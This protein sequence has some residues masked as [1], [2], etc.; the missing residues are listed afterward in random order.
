LLVAAPGVVGG[1]RSSPIRTVD[2]SAS[3]AGALGVELPDVDGRAV[4]DLLPRPVGDQ[5]RRAHYVAA[6]HEVHE[7]DRRARTLERLAAEHHITRRAVER[8]DPVVR[9]LADRAPEVDRDLTDHERRIIYLER[10][11]SVRSTMAWVEQSEV[12][13]SLLVSVITPT[14]NRSSLLPR[15]IAS[16]LAQSYARWEHVVIDDGSTDP[17]P[18]VLSKYDDDRVKVRRTTGVGECAARNRGLDAATGDVIVYLD[19]DNVLHPDWCKA[20]VWAFSQR[21]AVEVLYGARIIDDVQRATGREPGALPSVQF[22][23]FDHEGLTR[24]N[25][26]D[27]GVMAHRS[28]LAEARFDESLRRYGDWDLF[29]RLTRHRPP[30]ELPVLAC[31]YSTEA[32]NR[33]TRAGDTPEDVEQLRAKFARLLES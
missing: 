27:M 28:G 6:P 15:A 13:E 1:R 19:D 4:P 24:H 32:D 18:E 14:R 29:W 7:S 26:A 3:L 10:L 21:P 23:P 30:L 2:V 20:V 31:Y 12:P 33:M 16:V 8:V 11:A 17:T 25:F 9:G 5:P 22:E